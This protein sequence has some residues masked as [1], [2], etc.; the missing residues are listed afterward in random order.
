MSEA[1]SAL[2]LSTLV[3]QV[4]LREPALPAAR[5]NVAGPKNG[6]ATHHPPS[7]LNSGS[8]DRAMYI[9]CALCLPSAYLSD[10]ASLVRPC[11]RPNGI[12]QIN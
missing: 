2:N 5:Q 10:V 6:Q 8:E 1:Q 3:R 11:R 4:T 7:S 9:Q 12:G